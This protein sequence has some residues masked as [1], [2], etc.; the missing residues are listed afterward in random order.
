MQAEIRLSTSENP[1]PAPWVWRVWEQG[2]L[3]AR[4]QSITEEEAQQAVRVLMGHDHASVGSGPKPGVP[5]GAAAKLPPK[6]SR[7]AEP[8]V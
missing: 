2:R 8:S 6:P 3:V 5:A 1:S 4:G 7:P